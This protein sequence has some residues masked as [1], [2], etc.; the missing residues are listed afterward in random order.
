MNMYWCIFQKTWEIWFFFFNE[1]LQ[2]IIEL[3]THCVFYNQVNKNET[4]GYTLGYRFSCEW[5]TICKKALIKVNLESIRQHFLWKGTWY[6][7][8]YHNL[9]L[10]FLQHCTQKTQRASKRILFSTPCVL[11]CFCLLNSETISFDLF[12][13]SFEGSP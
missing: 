8:I 2:L 11:S 13:Y 1:T 10:L 5:L 9:F 12:D 4:Q 6:V 3:I 7:F